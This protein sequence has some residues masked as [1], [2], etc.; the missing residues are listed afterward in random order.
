[1][2]TCIVHLAALHAELI[3][4]VLPCTDTAEAFT[5]AQD[6]VL[7]VART[8][9]EQAAKALGYLING[10]ITEGGG[11]AATFRLHLAAAECT[12]WQLFSLP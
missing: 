3:S 12:G 11:C 7:A 9:R 4:S 5:F 8:Q 10:N 1:M 6:L 2:S